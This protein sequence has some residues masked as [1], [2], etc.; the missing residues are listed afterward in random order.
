MFE[1]EI[2]R[3]FS[4]AHAI[5]M[6]GVREPLHGHDWGVEVVLAAQGL[7]EDGLAHD[8]HALERHID[9]VLAPFHSRNLNETAPFDLVNP[10]AEEVARHIAQ[11]MA[12]LVPAGL[13]LKSVRVTE[14]PGCAVRYVPSAGGSR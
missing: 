2:R 11:R 9:Q 5:V 10:T 6:K 13:A 14:A 8:F 1:L 3:S 12:A 4:A 7:D